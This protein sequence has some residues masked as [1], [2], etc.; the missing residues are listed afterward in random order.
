MFDID[1][2]KKVQVW[3]A[4]KTLA[5]IKEAKDQRT[6]HRFHRKGWTN[7]KEKSG[8]RTARIPI[9]VLADK[10]YSKY[11]NKE[12]PYEDRRKESDKFLR[13]NDV[14][15]PW[16]EKISPQGFLLVDKL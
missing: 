8:R 12:I 11:F 5:V 2:L 1:Y 14:R 10:E 7:D 16:G 6:I 15:T 4:Q 9:W 13:L 3:E